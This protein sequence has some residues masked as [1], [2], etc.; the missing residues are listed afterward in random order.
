[1]IRNSPANLAVICLI[2]LG[3][4]VYAGGRIKN[5]IRDFDAY[6]ASLNNMRCVC[7]GG[8]VEPEEEIII[9]NTTDELIKFYSEKYGV[10]ERLVKCILQRESGFN[11]YAEGDKG[12]AVGLAQFHLGTYKAFRKVMGL[13]QVDFRTDKAEAIKTLCWALSKDLG[14][15]WTVYKGCLRR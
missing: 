13:E 14:R 15:H 3:V 7:A 2:I 10:S 6:S 1:M 5:N 8:V 12:L 11:P 9:E 4:L